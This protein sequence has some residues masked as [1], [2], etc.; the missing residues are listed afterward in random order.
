M[1]QRDWENRYIEKGLKGSGIGSMDDVF[2][3]IKTSFCNKIFE[4][5]K[6]RSV[7]DYG[8]GNINVLKN[9]VVGDKIGF[10]WSVELI[11]SFIKKNEIDVALFNNFNFVIEQYDNIDAVL[12]F[13]VFI[14]NS[15]EDR[16][17]ILKNIRLL[18]PQIFIFSDF[19]HKDR[20]VLGEHCFP[21]SIMPLVRKIFSNYKCDSEINLTEEAKIYCYMKQ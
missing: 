18:K 9:L 21:E 8:C 19:V 11:N 14:H 1:D 2:I 16:I 15:R 10:D 12:C 3:S 13:E 20:Y 4:K 7:L 17:I 5:H 6:T